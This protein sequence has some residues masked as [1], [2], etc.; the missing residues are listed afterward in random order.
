MIINYIVNVF[1]DKYMSLYYSVPYNENEM[2]TIKSDSTVS[3]LETSDY[4]NFNKS[5]VNVLMLDTSKA[6][7][8]VTTLNYLVN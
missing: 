1:S 3:M 7:N 5:S 4:Y 8:R 6:F 2:S